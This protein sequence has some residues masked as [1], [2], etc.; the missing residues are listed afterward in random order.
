MAITAAGAW[1]WSG[2]ETTTASIFEP[3]LLEQLAEVVV[4]LRILELVEVLAPALLVDVAERDDPPVAARRAAVSLLPLPPTPMQ[5]MFRTSLGPTPPAQP[6][7][8]RAKIPNPAT[9]AP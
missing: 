6:C 2:V 1:V 7:R 8:P 3:M 4:D 5:A 9:E